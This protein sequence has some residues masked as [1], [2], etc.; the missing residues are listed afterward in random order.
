MPESQP[1][2][3]PR[4]PAAPHRLVCHP[5]TPCELPIRIEVQLALAGSEAGPGLLLRYDVLGDTTDLRLPPT[6]NP[7]RTDG[8]WQH[9]C[10]E[11]FVGLGGDP[12]YREFNFSPSGQ[13]AAY[14]FH[15]ERKRDLTAEHPVVQPHI[16]CD[17][18]AG[19]LGLQAWLPLHALPA[20]STAGSWLVGLCAV[21]ETADGELS[22]WALQH[23]STRPDFHHRGG[24]QN[25]PELPTLLHIA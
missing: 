15:S 24:W 25:L 4:L 23:P 18:S 12:H 7:G 8:L 5:A 10:F 20:P 3:A 17:A 11:A 22:Y 6:T 16:E 21:I 9:T 2:A 14:R 13:W 19:V 1:V